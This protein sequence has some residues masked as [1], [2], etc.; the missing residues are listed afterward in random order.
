MR[1]FRMSGHVIVEDFDKRTGQKCG[2][3]VKKDGCVT[4]EI[5]LGTTLDFRAS[6]L[7]ANCSNLIR[8]FILSVVASVDS[9]HPQL[10]VPRPGRPLSIPVPN[11][12][13]I[14]S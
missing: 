4:V 7:I 12:S 5:G 6:H 9:V 2:E 1:A 8:C 14:C 3:F 13:A 10:I 11:L